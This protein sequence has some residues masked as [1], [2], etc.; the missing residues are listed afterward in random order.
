MTSDLKSAAIKAA[1]MNLIGKRM[2]LVDDDPEILLSFS[3][4]YERI[5]LQVK[6]F[7]YP[8]DANDFRSQASTFDFI[9][10]DHRLG[11][12]NGANVAANLMK[13]PTV[14]ASIFIFTGFVKEDYREFKSYYAKTTLMEDPLVIFETDVGFVDR[15]VETSVL[16][17]M[18]MS[19]ADK[20]P[21]KRLWGGGCISA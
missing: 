21:N 10:V 15:A 8:E 2:A 4:I 3:G 12:T 16:M 17:Q 5:G 6:S 14:T 1:S 7:C 20:K 19:D 9:L 18:D 13:N 11:G